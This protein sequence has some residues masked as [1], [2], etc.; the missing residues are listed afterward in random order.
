MA[1]ASV[2]AMVVEA[3]LVAVIATALHQSVLQ[4]VQAADQDSR[5]HQVVDSIV[6][7]RAAQTITE[8]QVLEVGMIHAVHHSTTAAPA[9]TEVA[10]VATVVAM[11]IADTAVVVDLAVVAT[12]SRFVQERMAATETEMTEVIQETTTDAHHHAP[13]RA[14]SVCTTMVTTDGSRTLVSCV[15]TKRLCDRSSIARSN[16]IRSMQAW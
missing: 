14:E 8:V 2:A 11:A 1:E 16:D 4:P 6:D 12:A 5:D 10:I 7:S 15:G 13:M 9:A 3:A